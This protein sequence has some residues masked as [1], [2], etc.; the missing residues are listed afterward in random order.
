[1]TKTFSALMQYLFEALED[2]LRFEF[3]ILVIR[4]CFGFRASSFE[5]TKN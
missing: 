2:I 3:S 1:M 5:F 4:I